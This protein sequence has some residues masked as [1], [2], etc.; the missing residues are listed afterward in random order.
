MSNRVCGLNGLETKRF[1]FHKREKIE[2]L[3]CIDKMKWVWSH[4][5]QTTF[6]RLLCVLSCAEVARSREKNAK[7]VDQEAKVR[8]ISKVQRDRRAAAYH[9]VSRAIAGS[10]GVQRVDDEASRRFTCGAAVVV[11]VVGQHAMLKTIGHRQLPR[12]TMA[13]E[14]VSS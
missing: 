2:D 12:A 13:T 4:L 11:D 5:V 14:D 8:K 1:S 7:V 10:G 6:C 3:Q 9:S